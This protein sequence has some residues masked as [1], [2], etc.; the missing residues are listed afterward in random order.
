MPQFSLIRLRG[1]TP[2]KPQLER[3]LDFRKFPQI[4][5]SV[6]LAGASLFPRTEDAVNHA[7]VYYKELCQNQGLIN[8]LLGGSKEVTVVVDL[9]HYSGEYATSL[10]ATTEVLH[11]IRFVAPE[12]PPKV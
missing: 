8:N 11:K 10:S 2:Y 3:Y 12:F 1:N 9:I 7:A 4:N 6:D 5:L